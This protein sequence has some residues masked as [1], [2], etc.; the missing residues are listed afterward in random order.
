MRAGE[1][2]LAVSKAA[3]YERAV[4]DLAAQKFCLSGRHHIWAQ[5]FILDIELTENFKSVN[6]IYV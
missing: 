3:S 6:S 4:G 1:L 2:T 5:E